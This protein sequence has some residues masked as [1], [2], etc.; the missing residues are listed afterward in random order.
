ME[1]LSQF[2]F[3][4]YRE[5]GI[6]AGGRA[7]QKQL[8]VVFAEAMSH[9]ASRTR[10]VYRAEVMR[11]KS[12]RGEVVRSARTGMR[13]ADCLFNIISRSVCSFISALPQYLERYAARY[14]NPATSS[15]S[16]IHRLSHQ[17]KNH[18][19]QVLIRRFLVSQFER[20]TNKFYSF[21]Y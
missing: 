12:G 1:C 17:K 9:I 16:E 5:C 19:I 18:P 20:K 2:C 3:G 15:P 4:A 10:R 8:I 13:C 11:H 7:R 21:F 6:L 14:A